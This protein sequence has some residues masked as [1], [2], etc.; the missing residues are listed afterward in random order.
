VRGA[1]E[2][3]SATVTKLQLMAKAKNISVEDLLSRYI[4]GL[5]AGAKVNGTVSPEESVKALDDWIA[6]FPDAPP[7]SDNAISRSSIYE[8]R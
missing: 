8:D 5:G 3:D 2:I 4:P 6:A 7:L 1:L